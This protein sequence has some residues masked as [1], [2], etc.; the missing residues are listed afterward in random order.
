LHIQDTLVSE[1]ARSIDIHNGAQK[2]LQLGR[3][4]G[5]FRFKNKTLHIVIK[6]MVVAMAFTLVRGM[7]AMFTMRMVVMFMAVVMPMIMVVPTIVAVFLMGMAVIVAAV[8]LVFGMS[9]VFAFGVRVMVVIVAVPEI[10]R[11]ILVVRVRCSLV[12]A[13]LDSLNG[14]ALLA[15]EVH[16]EVANL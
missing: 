3:I 12:D 4:E 13:K 14:L 9:L 11:L 7:I 2:I 6:M 1:H 8:M 16:V 10:L 15:L 5:S